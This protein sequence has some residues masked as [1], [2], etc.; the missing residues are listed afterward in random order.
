[1]AALLKLPED[2]LDGVLAEAAEGE[3]V[4]AANFNSPDQVVIAGHAGAVRRAMELAKAA[5]ARR[6]VELPVSAPFHC[7]LMKPAQE[8]LKAELD[9]T[10]FADLQCPLMNNW[11]ARLVETGA[12]ARRGLFEQIPNPVRWT[13]SMRFLAARG[14]DRFIEV[15]AGGVLTGLLRNIDGQL[16]CS[17]FGEA[18]ERE[19]LHAD[20]GF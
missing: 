12:E 17:R 19:K 18:E 10:P 6:A 7:A 9:A 16:K 2:R 11:E 15:G 20:L 13:E 1:M 3:V 14:V 5:G 4:S 8:K